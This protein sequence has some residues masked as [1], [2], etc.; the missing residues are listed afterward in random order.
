MVDNKD[1]PTGSDNDVTET[2]FAKRFIGVWIVVV[3]VIVGLMLWIYF[4]KWPRRKLRRLGLTFLP[5]P[6]SKKR[7]E[8]ERK[9]V[10]TKETQV[11]FQPGRQD[12]VGP[13][14]SKDS[15]L[16]PSWS[17]STGA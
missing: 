8:E 14:E 3:L 13:P 4:A 2:S 16:T 6:P 12:N 5:K 1:G 15:G 11:T 17:H 10:Q 7:E 9:E